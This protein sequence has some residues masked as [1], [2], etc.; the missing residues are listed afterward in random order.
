MSMRKLQTLSLK[1][2]VELI[3]AVENAPP[4]KKKKEIAEEFG[5]LPNTL[6]TI[7]K[8]K[9]RYEQQFYMST[10]V[11]C[12][13][14]RQRASEK[15]DID[16]ALLAWFKGIREKNIPLSGTILLSK[17]E[18]L[19]AGLGY[20]DWKCSVG[21]LDRFKKRHNIA[22]H[23]ICGEAGD[24]PIKDCDEWTITKLPLLLKDYA[25]KDIFNADETGL[26]W[27]LL[28]NKTLCMKGETCTGGKLSKERV[29]VLVAANMDGSEK[30]PL[31]VIGKYENPRCFKNVKTLPV[32]YVANKKAWMT[33]ALFEDW[34]K[35]LD[36]KMVLQN[37]KIL[38]FVDNCPAH[39]HI[40][41]LKAVKLQ[42]LPPNTTARLQPCD[43]GIIWQ[44]K[45]YYRKKLMQQII[46][47]VDT[48]AD[49]SHL[50]ISLLDAL[51]ILRQSWIEVKSSGINNCFVKAG[52]KHNDEVRFRTYT[53]CSYAYSICLSSIFYLRRIFQFQKTLMHPCKFVISLKS[54]AKNFQAFQQICHLWIM[55]MQ[56][57][58]F[59]PL[60][61]QI[62]RQYF[63]RCSQKQT[64]MNQ[65]MRT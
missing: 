28:P 3:Q 12:D 65:L 52:F 57:I 47:H 4:S 51:H 48:E 14:Q 44:L 39:P 15:K 61:Y 2:K 64:K 36:R 1:R 62:M 13:K 45:C 20:E 33:A 58:F 43:Q 18:E 7:L 42:F 5:V 46:N 10:T 27:R 23:S 40:V 49:S 16:V 29:T 32:S 25:A 21:W 34:I 8:D 55:S 59:T 11:N 37:R 38:L 24:V 22:F 9:V 60:I 53:L 31:L 26:F 6:S 63:S 50:K 17:A 54:F 41:G 56:I 19:A 30:L 35:Q